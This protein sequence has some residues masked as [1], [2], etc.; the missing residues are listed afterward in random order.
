[1]TNIIQIGAAY[2]AGARFDVAFNEIKKGNIF[3]KFDNGSE[4]PQTIVDQQDHGEL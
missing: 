3:P 1:M 2:L 4:G